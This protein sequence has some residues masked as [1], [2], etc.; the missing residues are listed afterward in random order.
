M[1]FTVRDLR[2]KV[3]TK[4]GPPGLMVINGSY[5]WRPFF[6]GPKYHGFLGGGF[7]YTHSAGC[8]MGKEK[9]ILYIFYF[10]SY[11]GK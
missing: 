10:H 4:S 3:P 1:G 11:L 7:K 2:M 6:N 5:T 9:H 8:R